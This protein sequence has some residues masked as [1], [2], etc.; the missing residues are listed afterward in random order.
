[1]WKNFVHIK[2][3]T[4]KDIGRDEF[5]FIRSKT[6]KDITDEMSLDKDSSKA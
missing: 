3:E 4:N 1:M 6:G 2:I 5:R